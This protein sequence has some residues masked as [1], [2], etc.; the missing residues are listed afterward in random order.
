MI[1]EHSLNISALCVIFFSLKRI[2][3]YFT[4]QHSSSRN[5]TDTSDLRYIL[6][7]IN[8]IPQSVKME[9]GLKQNTYAHHI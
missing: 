1:D 9:F 4:G 5:V 6:K 3:H 2:V 8:T 7:F